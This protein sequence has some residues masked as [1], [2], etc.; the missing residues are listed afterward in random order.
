MNLAVARGWYTWFP[1]PNTSFQEKEEK[2][3]GD[4]ALNKFFCEIYQDANEDTRRAMSKSFGLG[5]TSAG[6][7]GHDVT[8]R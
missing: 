1:C 5:L 3:D 8:D 2:L 6:R 4:A 7:H